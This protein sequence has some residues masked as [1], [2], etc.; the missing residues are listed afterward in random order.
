M[1][2]RLMLSTPPAMTQS[3]W[4]DITPMAAKLAACC[5]EPHMRSRVVP[6][7]SRGKP[8]M[9]AALR[10]MFSPCSPSW[11]TQP[12][13]TSSTSAGSMPV[14]ATS[15]FSVSARRSSGR[16]VESLPLRLPTAV[17]AAPTITA[18]FM[19]CLRWLWSADW[20]SAAAL[21][22]V[23]E[24]A[25]RADLPRGHLPAHRALVQH[26]RLHVLEGA[27]R[28]LQEAEEEVVLGPGGGFLEPVEDLLVGDGGGALGEGTFLHDVVDAAQEGVGGRLALGEPVQRLDPAR[29]LGMRG[30]EGGRL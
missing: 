14:R 11:S 7:T 13:T 29:Q 20:S 2:T 22:L 8:P 27:T 6:Q 16:T 17:R 10:A 1:G 4:P 28:L 23:T 3:Y 12:M 19:C 30:V 24:L 15:A 9:R 26:G 21:D 25:E 5:P 18:L